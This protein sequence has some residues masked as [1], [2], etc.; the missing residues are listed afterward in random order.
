MILGA[1]LVLAACQKD[2][3]YVC[4]CSNN[5]KQTKTFPSSSERTERELWCF[6]I[7]SEINRPAILAGNSPSVFCDIK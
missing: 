2:K 7:Q 4:E 3:D 5:T 6:S 1:V